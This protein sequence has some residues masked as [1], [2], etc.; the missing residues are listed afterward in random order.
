MLLA[1]AGLAVVLARAP[2]GEAW[3]AAHPVAVAGLAEATAAAA[4]APWV[5]FVQVL[6]IPEPLRRYH[7]PRPP[8]RLVRVGPDGA[9]EVLADQDARRGGGWGPP[10]FVAAAAD[11]TVVATWR[12]GHEVLIA[13]PGANATLHRVYLD[14]SRECLALSARW[15][16]H[17]DDRSGVLSGRRLTADGPGEDVP[18]G[19]LAPRSALGVVFGDP[20]LAWIDAEGDLVAIDVDRREQRTI[21][22]P[23]TR[24]LEADGIWN[25]QLLAHDRSDPPRVHVVDLERAVC[26]SLPAPAVVDW[27]LPE[28]AFVLG[29]FWDPVGGT[30][31]RVERAPRWHRRSQVLRRGSGVLWIREVRRGEWSELRTA[32]ELEV[33]PAD[34]PSTSLPALPAALPGAAGDAARAAW[35]AARGG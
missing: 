29:G 19:A 31:H 22:L 14:G 17:R 12:P 20:W 27:C 5:A 24:G 18:L 35:R 13:P 21:A 32:A 7:A 25:G 3:I 8:W 10:S 33:R 1:A 23:S 26:R 15:L 2:Q 28:G 34:S 11:G 4:A 30:I 6:P 16:L 9:T